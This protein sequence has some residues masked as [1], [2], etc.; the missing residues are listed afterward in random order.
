MRLKLTPLSQRKARAFVDE[1]HRHNKAP[2]GDIFRVGAEY[3]GELVG[4][5]MVGRPV[6]RIVQQREPQT[7]ELIRL[8]TP[9]DA[10]KNVASM[11]YG[12]CWRAARALGYTRLITYT[13][14]S[15]R[16]TSLRA[17][18]YRI[19]GETKAQSWHRTARP[20]VDRHTIEDRLCWS[21]A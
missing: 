21:A 2:R 9:N 13:L 14:K 6:S 17:A 3:N 16:G 10:P 12:A 7:V 20:R 11:L 4:V 1:H 5:A 8:C 19:I 18:G 15:E